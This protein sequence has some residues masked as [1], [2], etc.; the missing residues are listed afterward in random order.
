MYLSGPIPT[1][2]FKHLIEKSEKIDVAKRKEAGMKLERGATLSIILS[3]LQ[4][5]SS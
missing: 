3:D 2:I 1:L 4:L 5:L